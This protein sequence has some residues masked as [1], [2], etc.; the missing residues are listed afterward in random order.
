MNYFVYV[1]CG[2]KEYINELNFSL[3]FLRHFSQYPILVLTDKSRNEIE[4][5][6]DNIIDIRTPINYSNHQA[7][8]YLETSLPHHVNPQE[9]DTYCY[10]DSDVIAVSDEINQVFEHFL[11]PV[12]FAQDHCTIDYFSA[13]IMKC[14]CGEEFEQIEKQFNFLQTYFPVFDR[15]NEKICND[16]DQLKLFFRKIKENPFA[17]NFL[18]F[19]YIWKRYFSQQQ[20]LT[21]NNKFVFDKTDKCWYNFSGQ[22]IDYDHNYFKKRLWKKFDIRFKNNRWENRRGK[23]LK[24]EYPYCSH[25]REHMRKHYNITIPAGWRQWNGGVFLFKKESVDFM[26]LWHKNMIKEFELTNK[27][28]YDDQGTLAACA[29]Q[30]G[31]QNIKPLSVKFN[32]IADYGNKNVGYD[33]SAG[34]TYNGFNTTFKPA[35]LHIYHHWGDESWD[36]W[37]SVTELGQKHKII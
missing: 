17:G 2:G 26:D 12:R 29:W 21:M 32:F 22:L 11:L 19:R 34:Y 20:K 5:E 1:V 13:G 16:S 31:A 27:R 25:L 8:L 3:K 23:E 24:P 33:P 37:Q 35:F 4:I 36:I 10:L 7:H 9:D 15:N 14:T 28:I 30:L 6:H 18:G